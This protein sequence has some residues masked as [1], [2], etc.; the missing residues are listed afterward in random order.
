[1]KVLQIEDFAAFAGLLGIGLMLSFKN[2]VAST[3]PG[4][5]DGR[6]GVMTSFIPPRS[7]GDSS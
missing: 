1:M 5:R 2:I 6:L 4:V 3:S 7:H